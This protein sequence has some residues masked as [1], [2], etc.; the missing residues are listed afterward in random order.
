MSKHQKFKQ[1]YNRICLEMCSVKLWV[2]PEFKWLKTGKSWQLTM[3]LGIG[4]EKVGVD[5]KLV[6]GD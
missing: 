2:A 5:T 1:G 3:K 6:I 4:T